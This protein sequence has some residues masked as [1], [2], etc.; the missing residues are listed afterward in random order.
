M[1]RLLFFSILD[2]RQTNP[3][4]IHGI[5]ECISIRNLSCKL[6]RFPSL[7]SKAALCNLHCCNSK[8]LCLFPVA[9]MSNHDHTTSKRICVTL[10]YNLFGIKFS[11]SWNQVQQYQY[12]SISPSPRR[13]P[14]ATG[15]AMHFAP[16]PTRWT[17]N[18]KVCWMAAGTEAL[19]IV[20]LHTMF[21]FPSLAASNLE[22]FAFAM[23][24]VS[25]SRLRVS[26]THTRQRQWNQHI[27]HSWCIRLQTNLIKSSSFVIPITVLFLS[28]FV[29]QL[30]NVCGAPSTSRKNEWMSSIHIFPLLSTDL[31]MKSAG[32]ATER[33]SFSI[34]CVILRCWPHKI[35]SRK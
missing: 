12:L 4:H 6:Y 5:E 20:Y 15:K 32:A 35:H 24:R 31:L 8:Y 9:R 7:L 34:N 29:W 27:I 33:V 11:Q 30:K 23:V 1:I 18:D 21:L 19:H 25:S 28:F 3:S 10:K 16:H 13:K 17:K 2:F 14:D 22:T 26:H